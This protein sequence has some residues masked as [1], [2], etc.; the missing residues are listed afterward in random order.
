MYAKELE[1]LVLL[2]IWW[3]LLLWLFLDHPAGRWF[4]V[5]PPFVVLFSAVSS[6]HFLADEIVQIDTRRLVPC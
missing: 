5:H 2:L 4:C 3:L 6:S 1:A